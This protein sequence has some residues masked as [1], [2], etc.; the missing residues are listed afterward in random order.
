MPAAKINNYNDSDHEPRQAVQSR[1]MFLIKVHTSMLDPSSWTRWSHC[2]SSWTHY[3]SHA[4]L[5]S[6][7]ASKT[8]SCCYY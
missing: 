6:M 4:T 5:L 3:N 1:G 8:Y 2:Q 7:R